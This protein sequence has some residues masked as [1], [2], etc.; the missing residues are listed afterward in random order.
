MIET[1][2]F[3]P[4]ATA[5]RNPFSLGIEGN[6][7]GSNTRKNYLVDLDPLLESANMLILSLAYTQGTGD[8]TLINRHVSPV[9]FRLFFSRID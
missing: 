7:F 2:E 4:N 6:N 5:A 3:Y 1:G 9:V 8:K